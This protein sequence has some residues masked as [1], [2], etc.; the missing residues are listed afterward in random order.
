MIHERLSRKLEAYHESAMDGL[1]K[2]VAAVRGSHDIFL[3]K[4]SRSMHLDRAIKKTFPS[5][6]RKGMT[7]VYL[8]YG[9]W[10]L[11]TL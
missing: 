10:T 1:C 7:P 3:F 11:K 5:A 9:W 4:A 8:A 2:R 6:Y